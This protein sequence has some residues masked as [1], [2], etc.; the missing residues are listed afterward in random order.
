MSENQDHLMSLSDFA[1]AT[2][3]QKSQVSII[4]KMRVNCGGIIPEVIGNRNFINTNDYP[5]SEFELKT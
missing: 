1:I 5:V 4:C 3:R 2:G